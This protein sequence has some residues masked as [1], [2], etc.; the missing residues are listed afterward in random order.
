MDTAT[1]AHIRHF[2][3]PSKE[4]ARRLL[5]LGIVTHLGAIT[6]LPQWSNQVAE[7]VAKVIIEMTHV[8]TAMQTK[9]LKDRSLAICQKPI[10][11]VG[12][13]LGHQQDEINLIKMFVKQR[14]ENIFE[15]RCQREEQTEEKDEQ[16]DEGM[17]QAIRC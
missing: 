3:R 4:E 1:E 7:S 10:M 15:A 5:P 9:Q 2:I 11:L 8:R 12:K 6:A 16:G 17:V 13:A 14:R